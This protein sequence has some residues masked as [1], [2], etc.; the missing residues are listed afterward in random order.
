MNCLNTCSIYD[1]ELSPLTEKGISL[2]FLEGYM[3]QRF[4]S[5]AVLPSS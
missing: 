5:L 4:L 1:T 3:L 2:L